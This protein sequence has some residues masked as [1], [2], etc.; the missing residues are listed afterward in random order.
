M[1]KQNNN[2]LFHWLFFILLIFSIGFR[3]SL[4]PTLYRLDDGDTARDYMIARHIAVYHEYPTIG[5][6]NAIYDSVRASPFYYYLLSIPIFIHDSVYSIGVMNI[7]LQALSMLFL[8][9]LA[10]IVFG[11]TT[12]TL[13]AILLLFNQELFSQSFYMIQAHFGHVFFNGSYT[14]LAYGYLRKSL[15]SLYASI[16]LFSL[17]CIVS[18][19]GFPA[20]LGYLIIVYLVLRSQ[21]AT[22]PFILSIYGSM[23]LIGL[24][25]YAPTLINIINLSNTTFLIDEP[26]YVQSFTHFPTRIVDNLRLALNDW[27]TALWLTP[28]IKNIFLGVLCASL[29]RF[30]IWEK[31]KITRVIIVVILV[32][33]I[34]VGFLAALLRIETN[35]YQY[36]AITGLMLI[37]VAFATSATWPKNLFGRIA[38]TLSIICLIFLVI[39]TQG[40]VQWQQSQMSQ[41]Q[42]LESKLN[43]LFRYINIQKSMHPTDWFKQFQIAM[44]NGRANMYH[45]KESVIWNA[46]ELRYNTPLVKAV[47]YGYN[48]APLTTR[49]NT[50]I[51]ICEEYDSLDDA[52]SR[53]IGSFMEGRNETVYSTHVISDES[54]DGYIIFS[55]ETTN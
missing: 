40:Y 38:C 20:L 11:Q 18:F 8:Y 52:T 29:M 13:T 1:K 41:P 25:A 50:Y 31:A 7:L 51:V 42:K 53:C 49:E 26:V 6:N 34:Q 48:Y 5:P 10:Y 28:Q 44:Y 14:L 35:S 12:A 55:A 39:P 45:W 32:Y 46:L 15:V 33:L 22:T 2:P 36:D 24:I 43:P 21:K 17:G 16:I 4:L 23:A 3:L 47:N 54:P 9:T 19:H 27:V 37:L 30:I